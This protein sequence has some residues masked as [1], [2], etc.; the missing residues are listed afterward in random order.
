MKCGARVA[1]GVAGGYFLGR[2]KKM[3]LAL[4]LGGMAAGRRAGGPGELLAQGQR[5]LNSS[6]EL[7]ALSD[8]VRGRLVDAGKGAVMA[9]AAKQVSS[10]TEKVGRRVESLG[11][12]GGGAAG[13]ARKATGGVRDTVD[14]RGEGPDED[15]PDETDETDETDGDEVDEVDQ[16]DDTN[17]LDDVDAERPADEPAEQ[18]PEEAPRPRRRSAKAEGASSSASRAA[19]TGRRTAAAGTRTARATTSKAAS[20]G[21]KTA[22]GGAKAA[23]GTATKAAS[24]TT[25]AATARKGGRRRSGDA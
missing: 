6:P 16:V 12:L 23:S 10:L 7:S 24:G 14:P 18:E 3:K 2:T 4:M 8:Q 19:G 17:D 1:L 13:S 15:L 22:R 21:A 5:L 20:G 9:V 25:K 11:D